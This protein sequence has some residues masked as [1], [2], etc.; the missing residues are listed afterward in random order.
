MAHERQE[1]AHQRGLM[2]KLKLA[3]FGSNNI[4]SGN[5]KIIYTT[6]VCRNTP[7]MKVKNE[8]SKVKNEK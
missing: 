5:I 3:F 6:Y 2:V 8:K 4:I 7:K 1:D